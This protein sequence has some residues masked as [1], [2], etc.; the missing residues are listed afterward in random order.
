MNIT[1]VGG[2]FGGVKAA[3][4]LAKDGDNK[5]TLIT[6]NKNFVYYPSLYSTATGHDH[7]E[8]WTPLELIFENTPN[9]RLAYDTI[10]SIN[11]DKKTLTGKR[12]KYHYTKLI[13]ALGS[14]TTYFGI[15]GLDHYSYGIKS[16][17]EIRELQ[18]HLF[19]Q[20]GDQGVVDKRY[21]IVGGG[22]TGV[23]LAGALGVYLEKL[24]IF[25]GLRE[26]KIRITLVEASPRVLP[27]MSKAAS[28]LAAK[29][30]RSL[31]VKIETNKAVQSA[32]ADTLMVNDKPLKTQTVI[33]TSGV[34]NAPF[35]Q[36]N[37]AHFNLTPRGKVIV[38][39]H[40]QA[41][42]NIYVIG[43]NA[44]TPN[45]GLAQT[46]VYDGVFV[47][48]HLKSLKNGTTPKKY[49]PKNM[50]TV[51]PI[52][53]N[54]A[55]YERGSFHMAGVMGAFMRDLA[56]IVG[57]HDVLPMGHAIGAWR[58]GSKARLRIPEDLT[59]TNDEYQ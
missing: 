43:D 35:F 30:L 1:I 26:Q 52:G 44:A 4:E 50:G 59:A 6:Q 29:R 36:K 55:I 41:R 49:R 53:Y 27:R 13:L 2:G 10:T 24:R 15:D 46:A 14:V 18:K 33:W 8:S 21:V 51:V 54:W 48:H 5:I 11:P 57:H 38:D 37:K 39:D 12:L 34:A 32:T 58:A 17:E 20:M 22:P 45:S 9:V 3:L 7:K 40:L 19:R 23:E 31:G 16:E 28:R 25:F 42:P 47:A 56:D